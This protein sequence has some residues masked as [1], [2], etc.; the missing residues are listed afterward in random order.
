MIEGR[1]SKFLLLNLFVFREIREI[2]SRKCEFYKFRRKEERNEFCAKNEEII[3]LEKRIFFFSSTVFNT[4]DNNLS[5]M[6]NLLTRK[7]VYKIL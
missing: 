3:K 6:E 5:G 4:E 2:D 7:I 1:K